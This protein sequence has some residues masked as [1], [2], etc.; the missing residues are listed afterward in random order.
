MDDRVAVI[1]CGLA[2][3]GVVTILKESF[4]NMPSAPAFL[5]AVDDD[6]EALDLA[7]ADIKAKP[8]EGIDLS[9]YSIVF[10]VLNPSEEGALSW[11]RGISSKAS[12]KKAFTFGFL[13]KPSG[14][15]PVEDRQAYGSFDAAALI[16]EGW[17]LQQRKGKDAEYAMRIALNFIAHT[18][19]FMSAALQDGKLGRDALWNATHGRVARFAATSTSQPETLYGMSMSGIDRS[20]VRSAMLF[21]PEDTDNVMARRIFLYVTKGLPRSVEMVAMRIKYVE[22]F[23]I[24]ALL[25]S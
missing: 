5:V 7:G 8:G 18:I 11:A 19:T 14:G 20:T 21:M 4:S 3:C 15:W 10:F 22:P 9:G 12:E 13:I 1:G 2:G 23:R 25:A 6:E 17:V 24:V 16:D